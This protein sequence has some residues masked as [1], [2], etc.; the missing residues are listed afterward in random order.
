MPQRRV[1]VIAATV[2]AVISVVG[3]VAAGLY[4]A[5]DDNIGA[6]F[7]SFLFLLCI[8]VTLIWLGI[9]IA[10]SRGRRQEPRGFPV[11]QGRSRGP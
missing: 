1:N 11:V 8:P 7:V 2:A 10:C 5:A 6:G 9:A 3:F 4:A